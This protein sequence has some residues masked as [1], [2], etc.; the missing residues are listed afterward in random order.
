MQNVPVDSK[1]LASDDVEKTCRVGLLEAFQTIPD[2]RDPRGRRYELAPQLCLVTIGLLS[3]CENVSHIHHFG[4]VHPEMLKAL[5]YRPSKRPRS[6][7]RKGMIF[8]PNEGTLANMLAQV[9]QEE[10]NRCLGLWLGTMLTDGQMTA[11][12][13]G[14]A[15]RGSGGHVL[16]VFVDKLRQVLW[17]QDVGEKTNELSTLERVLPQILAEFPQIT[18]LTGDAGLCHKTIARQIVQAG[19]DYFLQLK[20]PHDTDVAT[21]RGAFEQITQA[22]KPLSSTVEKRGDLTGGK[23]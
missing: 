18:L 15:L 21:A 4:I 11:A 7:A 6:S 9:P 14:K 10:I 19:R 22:R 13:D 5:G 8:S 3:G 23:L 16:S 17:Q 12:I 20:A 2:A 1:P